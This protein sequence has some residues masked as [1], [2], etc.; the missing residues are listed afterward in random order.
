MVHN[1]QAENFNSNEWSVQHVTSSPHYP[2]SNGLAE[3]AVKQATNLL[4]KCK[5][6]SDP[7]LG[8]LNLRN[9]PTDQTLGSLA[10]QLMSSQD[11][12]IV[13]TEGKEYRRNRR[14]LLA[15]PEPVPTRSPATAPAPPLAAVPKQPRT[16][17]NEDILPESTSPVRCKLRKYKFNEDTRSS[18]W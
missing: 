14:H 15:V 5:D 8:L 6:S 16:V 2:Q 13:Q 4:C 1:S 11:I 18:Q 12:Y 3:N 17:S 9:V 7:L 10:Q